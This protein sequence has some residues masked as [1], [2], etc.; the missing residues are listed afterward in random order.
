MPADKELMQTAQYCLLL[1]VL[2]L[3]TAAR[4][5]NLDQLPLSAYELD[6]AGIC[7]ANN[8]L[9][10]ARHQRDFNGMP[11]L[12]PLMLCNSL[13]WFENSEFMVRLPSALFGMATIYLAFC[14]GRRFFSIGTG[15]LAAAFIAFDLRFLM[16]SREGGFHSMQAFVLLLHAYFFL[17]LILATFSKVDR[18]ASLHYQNGNARLD[19]TW[20]PAIAVDGPAMAGFVITGVIAL[21]T[22]YTTILCFITELLICIWAARS[23]ASALCARDLPKL[24][25]PMLIAILPLLPTLVGFRDWMIQTSFFHVRSMD[26]LI[27]VF[28]QL[29]FAP[30]L[31]LFLFAGGVVAA[32]VLCLR[33]PQHSSARI[34]LYFFLLSWLIALLVSLI[35]PPGFAVHYLFWTFPVYLLTAFTLAYF[36]ETFLPE[37]LRQTA[38]LGLIVIINVPILQNTANSRALYSHEVNADFRSIHTI[39]SQEPDFTSTRATIFASSPHLAFYLQDDPLHNVQVVDRNQ[40]DPKMNHFPANEPFYYL[41]YLPDDREML[42]QTPMSLYLSQHYATLCSTRLHWLLLQKFTSLPT[43]N[44]MPASTPARDCRDN[45]PDPMLMK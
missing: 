26:E 5:Y 29:F 39:L 18:A 43:N 9:E 32:I 40:N 35:T 16:A 6:S 12:Y 25:Q 33:T 28:R 3:A 44:N 41:E 15:L 31:L 17:Q 38:I 1:F 10:L 7:K 24:W 20:K 13:A 34:T 37:R 2:A 11:L 42:T 22:T 30:R 45:R 21:Y 23:P 14:I 27:P 36:V 8:W 4:F 19:W